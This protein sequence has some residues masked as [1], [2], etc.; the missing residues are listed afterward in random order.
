MPSIPPPFFNNQFYEQLDKV[1]VGSPLSPLIASFFVEGF[2][3]VALSRVAYK[4]T[5]WFRYIDDTVMIWPH[6][7]EE[8]K[9]FLNH[10]SNIQFTME[11]ESNDH[12]PFLD[13]DTDRRLDGSLG[14]IVYRKPIHSNLY[15]NTEL[16]HHHHH[17]HHSANKHSVLS[18]LVHRI[19]DICYWENFPGDLEFLCSTFTQNGL[20]DIHHALNSPHRED[21]SR[22][23]LTSMSFLPFVGSTFNSISR[24]L[25]RCNIKTVDLP[26]KVTSFLWPVKDE[27]A[28]KT[29]GMCSILYECDVVY[30]GQTRCYTETRIKEHF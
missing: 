18:I 5:C 24:V 27:L 29:V 19:R 4:P 6:R 10:F 25:M 16:H 21:T 23:T 12:L 7:P 8:L 9:K 13:N 2:E 14:C 30:I 17:H 3:E 26:R 22:E 20:S 11:T 15:M 28:L 1:A